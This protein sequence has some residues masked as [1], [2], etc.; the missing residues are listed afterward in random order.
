MQQDERDAC[1]NAIRMHAVSDE[2]CPTNQRSPLWEILKDADGVE[3]GRFRPPDQE[4]GC[5]T[6]M[7]RLSYLAPT[8]IAIARQRF[9]WLAYLLAGITKHCQWDEFPCRRLGFDLLD[10]VS[11]AAKKGLF[12]I[13]DLATAQQLIDGMSQLKQEIAMQA[14]EE[15]YADYI[16]RQEIE[17]RL[18]EE[19][20]KHEQNEWLEDLTHDDRNDDEEG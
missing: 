9:P 15:A 16:A 3:R 2:E 18:L 17:S 20:N 14:A 10:G 6:R 12:S 5:D 1:A 11:I 19:E 4:F 7:L 8:L 13:K